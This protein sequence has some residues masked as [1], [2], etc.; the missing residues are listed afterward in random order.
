MRYHASVEQ[1]SGDEAAVVLRILDAGGQPEEA[2]LARVLRRP[3]CPGEVVER[4]AGC[5][6]LTRSNLLLQLVVRHP[7]CPRHL[8][9]AA[10]PRLGWHDL[11]EVARDARTS[12][13]VRRQSEAKLTERL[14][15]LTAGERIALA[16]VAPRGVI[17]ALLGNRDPRCIAA[18]LDNPRFTEADALRLPGSNGNPACVLVLLRHAVWGRR[19]GV[20]TAIVQRGAVPVGI[21]LGILPALPLAEL[22]GVAASDA[23]PAVLRAAARTLAAARTRTQNG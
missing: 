20:A 21:A 17:A 11:L 8:A 9:L 14:V 10:L 5:R 22:R 13:A 19:R 2:L 18:L 6:W 23:A 15:S 4:L 7:R 3:S 12:P 16:R 1:S